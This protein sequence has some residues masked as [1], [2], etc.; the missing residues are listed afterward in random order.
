MLVLVTVLYTAATF[1]LAYYAY[2]NFKSAELERQKSEEFRQELGDLYQ[3]IVIST[4]TSQPYSDMTMVPY[5]NSIRR[6]MNLYKGNTKIFQKA[7]V[8]K[9]YQ[10]D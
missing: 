5:Y 7:D 10:W 8:P 3:A 6:F 2:K 4:I 1:C 9:E